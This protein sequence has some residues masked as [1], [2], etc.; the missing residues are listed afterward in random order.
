MAQMAPEDPPRQPCRCP[1]IYPEL[2]SL[3]HWDPSG[4]VLG[5]GLCSVGLA[6]G[7]CSSGLKYCYEG[8]P[9][10]VIWVGVR[11]TVTAACKSHQIHIGKGLRGPQSSPRPGPARP[12]YLHHTTLPPSPLAQS[13]CYRSVPHTLKDHLGFLLKCHLLPVCPVTLPALPSFII[14]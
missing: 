12:S 9:S 4:Q 8:P 14:L 2:A 5:Q 10:A 13:Q 7:G 1:F 6:R 11:T 3:R